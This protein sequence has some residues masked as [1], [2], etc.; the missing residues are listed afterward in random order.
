MR[1]IFSTLAVLCLAACGVA[2]TVPPN[3]SAIAQP[4]DTTQIT[5]PVFATNPQPATGASVQL[6]GNPGH[7]TLYYWIVANYLVGSSSVAGPFAETQARDTLDSS[8]YVTINPTFAAGAPPITFD[9]LKTTTTAAPTGACGCAV[10]GG[11][12][13]TPGTTVNDQNNATVSYTVNPINIA[14]L[15]MT[16]TNEVQSAGVSHLILRQNG[17]FVADLSLGGSGGG[18]GGSGTPPLFALF[19]NTTAIGSSLL[20]PVTSPAAG[21]QYALGGGL[22]WQIDAGHISFNSGLDGSSSVVI[23]NTYAAGANN[24]SGGMVL[25]AANATGS[26]C[27]G[28]TQIQGGSTNGTNNDA[29]VLA[30]GG[31]SN[32]FGAVGADLTLAAGGTS[33]NNPG[34]NVNIIPGSGGENNGVINLEGQTNVVTVLTIAGLA[35]GCLNIST[36]V[37]GSQ[38]CGGGSSTAFQVN[39]SAVASSSTLN[40]LNSAATNGL[41]LSFANPSVGNIQL[42]LSGALTS[43]GIAS[44]TTAGTCTY[45]TVSYNAQGQVTSASNGTAPVGFA[46]P[47]T[48]VGDLIGGTTA[49][50]ATRLAGP[51]TFNGVPEIL[52]STPAS[53]TAQPA[54][55]AI[56]GVP[57]DEQSS[58]GTYAIPVIDNA[59]LVTGTYSSAE[60]WTGPTLSNSWVFAALNNGTATI[61]YT[62]ASGVVYPGGGSSQIIPPNYFALQYTDLTNTFLPTLP[63]IKAFADTSA[64]GLAE[65]FNAT[66]GQFGT[67]AVGS[68]SISSVFG[69]TGAVVAAANDYDQQQ[70]TPTAVFGVITSNV[71]APT[72]VNWFNQS[73]AGAP[74]WIPANPSSAITV[75][76]PASGSQPASGRQIT[77]NNYGTASITVSPNGQLLNNASSSITILAGTAG[78]FT[79][80]GVNFNGY[81]TGGSGGGVP[82]PSGTGIAAVTSGSSWSA[83]YNSSNLIPADYVSTLNQNTTGNAGT[84]TQLSSSG[85]DYQVW[86]M[87]STASAQ[88]W[89]PVTGTGNFV[90]SANQTLTGT[91]TAG[92]ANFSGPVTAGG[93]GQGFIGVAGSA[94]APGTLP[95]NQ[96]GWIGPPSA[97][98]TSY[99]CSFPASGPAGQVLSCATPNGSG[100]SVGTWVTLIS[101]SGA[102]TWSALQTFDNS[103]IALLG[104]STGYTTFTSANTGATNY[105][106]TVPA[107]TGTLA[108]TNLAQTFAAVQTF[109]NSDVALL[110]SSTGYTTFTSANTGATNYTATVPANT[111]TLAETNLAQTF[112]ATQSGSVGA[113]TQ[114]VASGTAALGTS[115]I[116]SGSCA[117]VVTVSASGVVTTDVIKPGFNGDST[118]V[119]G[120]GASA[121]GAVLTIYPYPTLN[122]VNFKVCNWT[123]SSI[124]PGAL[125]LN[126]F[127]QR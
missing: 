4:I 110:G 21:I 109:G 31:C 98:F 36:G 96:A 115:A 46:N 68:S 25:E 19:T 118:A 97:S 95:S 73:G 83:V 45:C 124:T 111:G 9:V 72:S 50:A 16:L 61:T 3:Q 23:A 38:P 117:T 121:S 89:Q 127:V 52:T 69:R 93:T 104:S 90:L 119:T 43:A 100:V 94:T 54:F 79:S 51:T 67:I 62:P 22:Y 91:L 101:L 32:G 15:S 70:I 7:Q 126:W 34:G 8:H 59:S 106:A 71:S 27:A 5:M 102:N 77:I 114:N 14:T 40:F 47:M 12:G 81:V 42:G 18:I 105:T 75:T 6:V 57:I 26:A 60:N 2:Q 87:N 108:E 116:S 80:D 78:T 74:A 63:T 49:G 29:Y 76:L 41:T 92:S 58:G 85:G 39:G 10:T 30:R 113:Y 13:V 44:V 56:P 125:T 88:G 28:S 48:A 107:N 103:D 11:I 86:A 24:N 1:K 112:T 33:A 123:P 99:G 20:S 120:Y 64:G 82:Y 84:A 122:N 35:N 17:V 53:S 65:T 55:W 37:V 66:T